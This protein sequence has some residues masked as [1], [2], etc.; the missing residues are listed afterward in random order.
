MCAATPCVICITQFTAWADELAVGGLF[1]VASNAPGVVFSERLLSQPCNSS[2]SV[3]PRFLNRARS[4]ATHRVIVV[5]AEVF[6]L[7]M[8]L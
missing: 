5:E 1:S 2:R 3:E 6:N 8:H 7:H 4:A